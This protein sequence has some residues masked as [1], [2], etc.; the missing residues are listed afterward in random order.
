MPM[1]LLSFLRLALYHFYMQHVLARCNA[2]AA[3]HAQANI[4]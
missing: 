2:V 3:V 4:A 1:I